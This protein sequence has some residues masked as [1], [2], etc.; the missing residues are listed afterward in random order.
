MEQSKLELLAKVKGWEKIVYT[1]IPHDKIGWC[2][3]RRHNISCKVYGKN[4]SVVGE[5]CDDDANKARE[6][7]AREAAVI[8]LNQPS[9]SDSDEVMIMRI[10]CKINEAS[11]K[12]SLLQFIERQMDVLLLHEKLAVPAAACSRNDSNFSWIYDVIKQLNEELTDKE[13]RLDVDD[14]NVILQ[15]ENK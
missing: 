11:T 6:A 10:A 14:N 8:I 9:V 4:L 2:S 3:G 12:S 13:F 5:A 15:L 7:A 1:E